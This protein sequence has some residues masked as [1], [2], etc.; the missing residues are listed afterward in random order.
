M[1]GV[2]L[3]RLMIVRI[4]KLVDMDGCGYFEDRWFGFNMDL[5]VVV[6]VLV[7]VC[8]FG[9]FLKLGFEYLKNFLFIWLMVV[10]FFIF[11]IVVWK[12]LKI[13]FKEGLKLLIFS[14]VNVYLFRGVVDVFVFLL[15]SKL[16][17]KL[18][19][20]YNL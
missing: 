8:I 19:F 18:R 14:D 9:D 5:Y 13:I 3:K 1:F 15:N 2:G 7:W 17:F 16:I 20:I 6:D 10:L 11:F 4:F 12:I